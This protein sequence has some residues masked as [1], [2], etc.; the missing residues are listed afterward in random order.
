MDKFP[1][2]FERFEDDV[3]VREISSFREL[4]LAFRYWA[5]YKW[6]DTP[7]QIQALRVEAKRV[8][9]PVKRVTKAP[10]RPTVLYE[11]SYRAETVTRYGKSFRIYRDMETGRFVS[12]PPRQRRFEREPPRREIRRW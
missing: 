8:G 9:I 5:G 10:I 11:P 6:K 7:R 12:P 2:A 1:E 4:R 3:D